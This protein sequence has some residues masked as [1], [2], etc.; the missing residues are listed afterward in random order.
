MKIL[1]HS[2]ASN[3]IGVDPKDF[4]PRLLVVGD[5]DPESCR[6]RCHAWYLMSTCVRPLGRCSRDPLPSQ[7]SFILPLYV[8]SLATLT[9]CASNCSSLVSLILYSSS[10][11]RVATDPRVR[12]SRRSVLASKR[13]RIPRT[14]YQLF[15]QLFFHIR[16]CF[17][18]ENQM[19]NIVNI[20]YPCVEF[21]DLIVRS[22]S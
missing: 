9:T 19:S 14:I 20:V 7:S 18:F 6:D 2:M 21:L 17:N 22:R 3:D 1:W 8:H 16:G 10:F 15:C 11:V 5:E 13:N 12:L 4:F